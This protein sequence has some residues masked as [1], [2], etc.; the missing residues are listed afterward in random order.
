[1]RI[2]FIAIGGS[3]MHALAIDT[4]KKGHLVTGSDDEI[5]EPSRSQLDKYGLLPAHMGWDA[6]NI[7]PDIELVVLGMHAKADNP[8][9]QKAMDLDIR[10]VSFPAFIA[11][12]STE[13]KR[14]VIAGSHGKTTTTSMIMHVL[15]HLGLPFDYLV[16]ARLDGFENMV[17]ISDAPMIIIE[18]DEY[19]S[20][21][22]DRRPKIAHY[23]PDI[24]V[25]TGIEWD[26]MNVFP[27]DDIYTDQFQNYIGA[28]HD[29]TTLL[30]YVH[31]EKLND[32]VQLHSKNIAFISYDAH[33]YLKEDDQ[34]FLVSGTDKVHVRIFGRHNM[35]NLQAAL[36][37]CNKLGVSSSD[38]YEAIQTFT[39][40]H[41]RL[42]TLY[43]IGSHIAYWD[44]AHAPSKVRATVNAVREKHPESH[45]IACFE[46][47]TYS[48]LNEAFISNYHGTMSSADRK[49]IFYDEH[50]FQIKN[51]P[52]LNSAAVNSAFGGDVEVFTQMRALKKALQEAIKPHT[53]LLFM[54]SGTFSQ[55]D[56]TTLSKALF[57]E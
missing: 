51:L 57:N 53:A 21:A 2:H 49:F 11:E 34:V 28:L 45:F 7:T 5:Y 18:G 36:M 47:H 14:I 27:T 32:I 9:L 22:I 16:G 19:L 23:Q 39:G 38:F 1:M 41:K 13:K 24:T 46:L 26:H 42:Q 25:I 10:I 33:P 29:D 40:A 6:S 50:T 3:I 52:F 31:D 48:S 37:V 54:S 4:Q 8:E 43:A 55:T 30:H 44:F 12:L 17:S 15:K 35:E 56:L 20:S